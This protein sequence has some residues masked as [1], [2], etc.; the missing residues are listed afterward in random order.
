MGS[1][2]YACVRARAYIHMRIRTYIFVT[3]RRG[4]RWLLCV[5]RSTS[6]RLR[7]RKYQVH[8]YETKGRTNGDRFCALEKGIERWGSRKNGGRSV[9]GMN[10]GGERTSEAARD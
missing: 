4:N 9:G 2:I 8:R 10:A 6:R 1:N 3:S 5:R 7:S